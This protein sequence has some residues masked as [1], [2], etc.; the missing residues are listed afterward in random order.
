MNPSQ[1]ENLG[2]Q[3]PP[4]PEQAS[5]PDQA[6]EILP[7]AG[8]EA[9][10]SANTPPAASSSVAAAFPIGP[11]P[12]APATPAGPL[13]AAKGA[14]A[15]LI[16]DDDLIEKEW[17]NKAKQIVEQNRDDPYKQSENLT[18]F[19]SDYLKQRYGKTIKLNQ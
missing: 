1:P 4:P 17:V 19:K 9:A 16:T 7:A 5:A 6:G 15:S 12:V 2:I 13:P 8:P 10:I 18:V 3:L 11:L 14:A